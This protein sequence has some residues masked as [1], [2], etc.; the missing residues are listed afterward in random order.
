VHSTTYRLDA[1]FDPV[2]LGARSGLLWARDGFG[3]AGLGQA[4]VIPYGPGSAAAATN[5]LAELTGQD[6]VNTAGTGAVAFGALPFDP[7]LTDRLVVPNIVVGRAADGRRW[8]T[9]M[10]GSGLDDAMAHVQGVLD[11]PVPSGPEPSS[12]RLDSSLAPEIWR[13][14]VVGFARDRIRAGDLTK[15]VLARELRLRT[16]HPIDTAVVIDRLRTTFPA[17]ILFSVDGFVGA[18]PELLVARDGD[19][20]RAHPLAG[21]APRS[22]DP[23]TD[24]AHSAGLLGSKKDRWEHRITID[25]L[26][27][28]LLPFCS[29]VDAEPEPT[30]VTLANVHH[31]GTRVE[32]RLSSPASSVLELVAA[33]HPTP[34]VG[35]QPQNVALDLIEGLERADRGRYAGPCG[36]VDGA[37]NGAFAVSVRSAEISGTEARIF[38]GVG[39]VAD[40]DPEA[41][42]AE[43]RSKFQAML[44]ALIRP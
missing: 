2:T 7:Q 15:A 5:A 23:S 38:A 17:A 28:T 9:V 3:L 24:A 25:W 19:V 12:F 26:L 37:G 33:L 32:G 20:V 16:D 39:V 35:G 30:I 4:A 40:S 27:D 13:D 21:T 10:D 29:Y 8:L 34:A 36:W 41:E 44:G 14:E 1:D 31:L 6:E 11:R 42:L 18:S 43:T 22:S